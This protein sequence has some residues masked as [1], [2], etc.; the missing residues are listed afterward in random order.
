MFRKSVRL[1]ALVAV[2]AVPAVSLAAEPRIQCPKDDP[3]LATYLDMTNRM[4]IPRDPA[5][6]AEFYAPRFVSHNSDA[7][8]SDSVTLTPETFKRVYD[9]SNRS[10]GERGFEN[11]LILCAGP[12]VIARVIMTSKMTGPMGG[13]AATGRTARVTAIDIYRFENGKVVERWGN[14]DGIGMLWQLGLQLPAP[15]GGGA[16]K[17][18]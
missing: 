1:A 6:A 11:E 5:V 9:S 15:P 10:F 3:N 4:F 18:Q 14:N 2:V 12:Y 16:P 17:K 13:Q 8:G 7:G